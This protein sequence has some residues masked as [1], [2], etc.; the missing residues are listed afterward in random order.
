MKKRL[1][2]FTAILLVVVM[3]LCLIVISP[4]TVNALSKSADD[5]INWCASKIGQALDY[6]GAYGAQCVDFIMYYYQFLGVSGGGGNACDYVSN[7]LPSGF[8]RTNAAS[9][10]SGSGVRISPIPSESAVPP[11]R[12]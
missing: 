7:T 5:A 8:T 10:K 11:I 9:G 4:I 2:S 12:Q 3:M 6:D 1:R